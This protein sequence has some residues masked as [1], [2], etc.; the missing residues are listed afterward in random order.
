MKAEARM[1][2]PAPEQPEPIEVEAEPEQPE[3]T[4]P[5]TQSRYYKISDFPTKQDLLLAYN[6]EPER[7]TFED[8][9][10]LERY[11][12]SRRMDRIRMGYGWMR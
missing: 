7:F 10:K 2:K 8:S 9:E 11:L 1:R 6:E 4:E 5:E 12:Y 3:P